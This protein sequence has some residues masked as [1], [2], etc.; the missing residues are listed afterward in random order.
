MLNIIGIS[1]GFIGSVVSVLFDIFG[2]TFDDD[3]NNSK[4]KKYILTGL[5][6]IGI[7]FLCQLISEIMKLN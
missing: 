2:N 5:A 1:I 6:L 7:G 3:W 4:S